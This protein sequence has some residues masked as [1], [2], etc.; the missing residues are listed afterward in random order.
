MTQPAKLQNVE[1]LIDWMTEFHQ[2]A[3]Q[4]KTPIKTAINKLKKMEKNRQSVVV[5]KVQ[6][7]FTACSRMDVPLEISPIKEII[8]YPED[9]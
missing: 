5:E 7:Y 2:N 8:D 9:I 6:R 4:G 3:V 1:H